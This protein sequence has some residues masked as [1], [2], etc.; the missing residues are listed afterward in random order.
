MKFKKITVKCTSETSDAVSY[1]LH[2]AG[3][4]GEVFDDYNNIKQ[5]LDDKR[6]DYADAQLFI[7]TDDCAV[8]GYF[9]ILRLA[10]GGQ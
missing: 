9:T 1:A 3:S 2:E 8:M 5:V 6:W 10:R 4:M 7:P